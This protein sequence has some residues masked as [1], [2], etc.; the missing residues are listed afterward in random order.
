VL[1]DNKRPRD[2]SNQQYLKSPEEM[3]ALFADIPEALENTVELAR[4]CNVE[5]KF[6]TYYLPDFP[7]PRGT[8]WPVTSASCRAKA[9][10][11]ASPLH[12]WPTAVQPPTTRRGSSE[13]WTSSSRWGFPVTS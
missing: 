5:L 9:C 7:V 3:E 2:Y 10:S 11:N 1:A 13:N 8:T 6:G 4:R 12:R